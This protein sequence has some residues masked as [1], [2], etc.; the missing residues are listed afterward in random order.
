MK[1]KISLLLN[2]LMIIFEV[3][4]LIINLH[5]NGLLIE[6]Y[7]I[8]SNMLALVSSLI[9]FVYLILD[10][11]MPRWLEIFKY[12]TTVCLTITFLVVIF[13]L[14]PM[15]EFNYKFFL[16]D[17]AFVYQ[18]LLC[19][20]MAVVTFLFFDTL[21]KFN[22]RDYIRGLY[23]TV[24]YAI[25][26]ITLNIV[27]IVKGPYPFLMVKEQ[28]VMASV[29]WCIFLTLFDYLIAVCLGKLYFKFNKEGA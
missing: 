12:M 28:S 23:L 7:T 2:G 4:A 11:K 20:I 26:L 16:L 25:I 27:G 29:L 6:Y 3:I 24:I 9:Y 19:P 1:K 17:G 22:I 15:Y 13:I 14:A 10:E 18:H 21:H 5:N 8:D